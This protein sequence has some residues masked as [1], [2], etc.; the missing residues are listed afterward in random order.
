M[1]AM[2]QPPSQARSQPPTRGWYA[3][4]GIVAAATLT[5]VV[6]LARPL[7]SFFGE[8]FDLTHMQA[9]GR[10]EVRLE[11]AGM[12]TIYAE[13]G[14]TSRY[15]AVT[16]TRSGSP[17]AVNLTVT[18]PPGGAE[19]A[20]RTGGA[21]AELEVHG[22]QYRSIA[23][24]SAPSAGRVLVEAELPAPAGGSPV[25]LAVGP[26]PRP[27]DLLSVVLRAVVMIPIA[28]L[29]VGAAVAISVVTMVRRGRVKRRGRA[30]ETGPAR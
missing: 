8:T 11:R 24:F 9:P 6:L 21:T 5:G 18:Q 7:V 13:V 16:V 23:T 20:V 29:G 17:P 14:R 3:L 19:L 22:R 25:P 26:R 15:G 4:A 10:R 30:E 27:G 2:P 1:N 28:L 12:H